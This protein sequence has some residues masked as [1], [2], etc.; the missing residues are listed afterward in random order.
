MPAVQ[1]RDFS[2]ETYNLIKQ[3]AKANGRSI[4]Q[5]TKHIVQQHFAQ[6]AS[7]PNAAAA[8]DA[9]NGPACAGPL[10]GQTAG[11]PF[12]VDIPDAVEQRGA[13]RSALFARIV[14]RNYPKAARQLDSADLVRRMR[15][16]R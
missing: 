2:E 11:N 14:S 15:D 3:E 4:M 6:Q 10:A 8:N 7:T 1:V 9:A 13:R 12:A 16:G 5:Q